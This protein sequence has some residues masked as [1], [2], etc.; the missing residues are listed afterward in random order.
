MTFSSAPIQVCSGYFI[1]LYQKQCCL[2]MSPIFQRISYFPVQDRQNSNRTQNQSPPFWID[3][4]MHPNVSIDP[5]GLYRIFFPEYLSDC[6]SNLL[7]IWLEKIFKFMLLK[8]NQIEIESRHFHSSLPASF[9]PGSSHQPLS[10]PLGGT[11]SQRILLNFCIYRVTILILVH[12]IH[13]YCVCFC[14]CAKCQLVGYETE[15]LAATCHT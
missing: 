7:P 2:I 5:L 1:P 6:L 8:L 3:L 4:K 12:A 11:T 13:F 14:V 9:S 15:L 10:S